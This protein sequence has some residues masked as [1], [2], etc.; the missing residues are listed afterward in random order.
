MSTCINCGEEGPHY[1][2][3]SFGDKGEFIC[4]KK[5]E[6]KTETMPEALAK[7]IKRNEWLVEIYG[8]IGKPGMFA[9]AMIQNDIRVAE[10]AIL[11]Q[12]TVDMVKS[13]QTLRDNKE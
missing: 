8:E 1:A 2:G 12:D 9:K 10:K 6:K 5:E 4:E 3:P 11:D 7:E 13:L